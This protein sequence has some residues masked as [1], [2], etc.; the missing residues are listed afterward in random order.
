MN[1][2]D[3]KILLFYPNEPLLGV[4]P[5][6]LALL[7]AYLKRDGFDVKLFDCTVYKPKNK[8]SEI[9]T[10]VKLGHVVKT[11]YDDYVRSLDTDIFEDFIKVVDE[12]QPNIIAATLLDSTISFTVTFLEKIKQ[13]IKDKNITIVGGGVGCTFLYDRI[14]KTGFFDHVC[15]SEGEIPFTE[16]C[17]KLYNKEDCNHVKNFYS[18]DENGNIIKNPLNPL[19]NLD[20]L[21]PPDFSIYEDW[22][23][24]RP[25][26]E[27]VVRMAQIDITRGCPGTCTFCGSP[28]LKKK[29]K[30]EGCGSYYR[31]KSIDKV[32]SDIKDTVE[33]YNINFLWISSETFLGINIK[34]FRELVKKYKEEINLPFWTATR[35]DTLTEEKT[36]LLVE[37]GCEGIGIG[38]E[39]GDEYLRNTLLNKHLKDDTM[40]KGFEMLSKYHVYTTI[41]SMLGLPGETREDVFKTIE[42]NKK[43]SNILKGHHN[44]NI[45][46]FIPFSGT[47]LREMCIEKGYI[48][49]DDETYCS[50]FAESTLNMPPPYLSKED[51]KGL[52]KTISLY[53]KLPELYYPDIK[54]AEKDD[55]KGNIMFKKLM[56]IATT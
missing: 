37:M 40:Y 18:K 46:T 21:L 22:R 25:F 16:L 33:N 49:A 28:S 7:S 1:K 27:K 5:S 3:F 14:F 2:K 12:Y 29:F 50:L 56:K 11:D 31:M 47:K 35:L 24:Y 41:N 39:H 19:M 54:I 13:Q 26:H 4:T 53:I 55:K 15:I 8:V 23:F 6:N 48:D 42:V 34:K 44:I 43:V 45:Y 51:I 38:L 52:Q 32:I 10:R 17:N 9:D 36:Q 30:E 20:T